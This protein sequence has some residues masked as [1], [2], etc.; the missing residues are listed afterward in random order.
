MARTC[1]ARVSIEVQG[2]NLCGASVL[3]EGRGVPENLEAFPT[4]TKEGEGCSS[5][6]HCPLFP[7]HCCCHGATSA[8]PLPGH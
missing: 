6:R 5:G 3:V 1:R 8:K 7:H 4:G 2:R